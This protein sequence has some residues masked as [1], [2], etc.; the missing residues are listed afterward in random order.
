MNT[1]TGINFTVLLNI[2]IYMTH[3]NFV[4]PKSDEQAPQEKAENSLICVPTVYIIRAG[5]IDNK[6]FY[7]YNSKLILSGNSLIDDVNPKK[8]FKPIEINSKG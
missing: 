4:G 3:K 8:I 7:D 5:K 1:A 2:L 6:F